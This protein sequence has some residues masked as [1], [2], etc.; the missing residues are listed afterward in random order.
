MESFL[1]FM[2]TSAIIYVTFSNA[3]E[4]KSCRALNSKT[5]SV[6]LIMLGD[7]DLV[8]A[9][10][11]VDKVKDADF[12]V[13]VKKAFSKRSLPKNKK[14]IIRNVGNCTNI[15]KKK[16][17]HVLLKKNNDN[18]Y[19][20]AY[21]PV[22]SGKMFKEAKKTVCCK[23]C[24][25]N[26][27]KFKKS[28]QKTQMQNGWVKKDLS[29]T[30]KLKKKYDKPAPRWSWYFDGE[31]VQSIKGVISITSKKSKSTM[32]IKGSKYF[33]RDINNRFV[34]MAETPLGQANQSIAVVYVA[35]CKQRCVPERK[36]YCNAGNQ[37]S[38][39]CCMSGET[40]YCKCA[41]GWT[42]ERCSKRLTIQKAKSRPSEGKVV[43]SLSA[44]SNVLI[45]AIIVGVLLVALIVVSAFFLSARSKIRKQK[46]L[47]IYEYSSKNLVNKHLDN[48]DKP[49]SSSLTPKKANSSNSS[50]VCE[51]RP[52]HSSLTPMISSMYGKMTVVT[53]SK[54]SRPSVTSL[55]NG[56]GRKRLNGTAKNLGKR[57]SKS[58]PSSPH[59]DNL[60]ADEQKAPLVT[61][62]EKFPVTETP[63]SKSSSNRSLFLRRQEEIHDVD[64]LFM[65]NTN[66]SESDLNTSSIKSENL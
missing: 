48:F 31:P 2:L 36:A 55:S 3:T 50:L 42:G 7:I 39:I 6:A 64:D 4:I 53:D 34:C 59:Y 41:Y 32:K 61:K 47:N 44:S 46:N 19:D 28:F 33:K 18:L 1:Q 21:E 10:V 27:P 58:P 11:K 12:Q 23:K 38:S 16:K 63:S 37:S 52:R 8:L 35:D 66:S 20:L 40:A 65:K 26:P 62:I 45:M 24:V 22:V 5:D 51:Q 30:C 15:L 14:I 13:T 25:P 17:Y 57:S 49:R 54:S 43:Y 29:L 56:S 60:N 9:G